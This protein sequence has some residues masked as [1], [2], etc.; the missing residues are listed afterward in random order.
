MAAA[1]AATTA[2]ST[3]STT[4]APRLTPSPAC[5]YPFDSIRDN[6]LC[7]HAYAT[8]WRGCPAGYTS[9]CGRLA[10]YDLSQYTT[11]GPLIITG[12]MDRETTATFI[13]K[14]HRVIC[15]PE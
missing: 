14:I 12:P 11:P 7:D 15:C 6:D 1:S 13:T 2:S 3:S 8:S 5:L 9:A 10:D 4:L